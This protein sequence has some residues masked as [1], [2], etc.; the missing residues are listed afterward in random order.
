LG[1]PPVRED[2][3]GQIRTRNGVFYAGA[4]DPVPG[5][6]PV[7]ATVLNT[8]LAYGLDNE[9]VGAY[10]PHAPHGTP[11]TWGPGEVS[12]IH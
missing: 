10:N 11:P 1:Y 3:L 6:I 12:G 9:L 5:T 4:H 2:Y 8:V 7:A